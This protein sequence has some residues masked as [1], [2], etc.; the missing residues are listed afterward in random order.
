MRDRPCGW[1]GCETADDGDVTGAALDGLIY[2]MAKQPNGSSYAGLL[3]AFCGGPLMMTFL[4]VY[5]AGHLLTY[6]LL[7]I[8][9]DRTRVVPRWSAWDAPTGCRSVVG[10]LRCVD[11][12]EP[13]GGMGWALLPSGSVRWR[14]WAR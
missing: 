11:R 9:L 1:S 3:N 6:V 13:R 2:T 10:K 5:I 8:A 7:G 14:R 12:C 4:I